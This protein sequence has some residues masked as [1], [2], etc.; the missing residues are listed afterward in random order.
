MLRRSAARWL[1]L[2]A[3]L[4]ALVFAP[5][6]VAADFDAGMRAANLRNYAAAARAWRPLAEAGEARAQYHLGALYEE[7][8]GVK[9]NAATAAGWYRRAARQG[10][11]QAQNALAI[12]AIEGRGVERDPVEAYKWFALA[13]RSGNGFAQRNLDKLTAMLSPE[14]VAAGELKVRAFQAESGG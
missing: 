7:G 3:L 12:L 2:T 1:A 9:R 5:A 4:A 10:H 13:A 11:A 8:H 14:E 6:I